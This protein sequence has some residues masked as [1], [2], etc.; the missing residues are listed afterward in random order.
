MEGKKKTFKKRLLENLAKNKQIDLNDTRYR[1]DD[2][3][4]ASKKLKVELYNC[5][6]IYEQLY[7]FI[8]NEDKK[9]CESYQNDFEKTKY[10]S[11]GSFGQFYSKLHKFSEFTRK[12]LLNKKTPSFNLINALKES[13]LVP[14]PTGILKR[15]GD[16]NII[17]MNNMKMGD[18]YIKCLSKSLKIAD[19]LTEIHLSGNRITNQGITPLLMSINDNDNLIK[20]VSVLD[21][22]FNKL[23]REGVNTLIELIQNS[24]C[25]LTH[26]NLEAN[27]LGNQLI[28]ML[29]EEII[30]N[31]ADKISYLNFGQNN[32]NDD[33]CLC[34]ANM[35]EQCESLQVLIL[36]WNQLKNYGA[37]QI[38]GKLKSH[39]EIKVID[40]GWNLIGANLLDQPTREELNKLGKDD[41]QLLNLECE[42][43]RHN[44]EILSKKKLNP[45]KNSVS[46][47]A[48]ELGLLFKGECRELVHLDISHNNIG[49]MDS[50]HISIFYKYFNFKRKKKFINLFILKNHTFLDSNRFF[51]TFEILKIKINAIESNII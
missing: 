49:F 48:K 28:S 33:I 5:N 10:N 34:L 40:L 26:L 1:E 20:K 14:N 37:S 7:D 35:V 21:L 24:S 16:E 46:L 47:F 44:M 23:G 22:S 17:N 27:C 30:K 25:E 31:L 18:E 9:K 36:Y 12:E 13:N 11:F 50:Q 29:V 3:D 51:I 6:D 41:S 32:I 4:L 43:I 2:E 15:N 8:Y 42:E 38:I 45:I 19:H 39:K